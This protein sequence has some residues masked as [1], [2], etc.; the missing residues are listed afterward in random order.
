MKK[1]LFLLIALVVSALTFTSCE[2]N[3]GNNNS[4]DE[5]SSGKQTS[6]LTSGNWVCTLSEGNYLYFEFSGNDFKYHEVASK[7]NI[8]A[9]IGGSYVLKGNTLTFE[10]TDSNVEEMKSNLDKYEKTATLNGDKL[11]WSKHTFTLQK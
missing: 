11:L 5:P 4:D 9:W 6:T 1:Y 2:K 8:D 10:F 3:S 7:A